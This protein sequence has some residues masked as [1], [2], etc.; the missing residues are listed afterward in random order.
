MKYSLDVE[1]RQKYYLVKIKG[2]FI[3]PDPEGLKKTADCALDTGQKALL[4]DLCE[5]TA[6]DSKGI[7][8]IINIHKYLISKDAKVCLATPSNRIYTLLNSCNLQKVLEIYKS[9]DEADI[10][11]SRN[12]SI[13]NRGFYIFLKI[14]EEFD[15]LVLKQL[16]EVI[17]ESIESGNIH[18]VFDFEETI[19]ISSVGIGSLINLHKKVTENNGS[20]YLV[21]IS[22]D[23][24]SL[25]EDTN[26]LELL[27]EYKTIDEI[28][29][30]L[31]EQDLSD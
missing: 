19:H 14:P 15:L 7:G 4:I 11:F 9:I 24:R 10:S 13:E 2:N 18:I 26:V 16:K 29:E 6:I 21:N 3:N 23:V 17:D 31:L 28:E 20:I 12:I 22:S 25:L 5:A 8:L 1:E 30:K 27:P